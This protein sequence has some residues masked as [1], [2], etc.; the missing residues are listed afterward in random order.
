M[1][2]HAN[3]VVL[4]SGEDWHIVESSRGSEYG[5]CGWR[6]NDR[7][8]HSRLRTIGRENV[9]RDCLRLFEQQSNKS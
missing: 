9:C 3:P 2:D 6:L 5:L 7:R 4:L 8:A 1:S